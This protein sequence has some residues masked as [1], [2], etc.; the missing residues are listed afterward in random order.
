MTQ[1]SSVAK[2][3]LTLCDPMNRSTP[4]LP[5]HHQL[6]ESTQTHVHWVND[7]IQPSHPLLFPSPP[8]SVFPSIRVFSSESLPSSGFILAKC[9]DRILGDLS[10]DL[11]N[12]GA[13]V[14]TSLCL[15][16]LK[17]GGIKKMASPSK[18]RR[19]QAVV[20]PITQVY[21]FK[22]QSHIF[23]FKVPSQQYLY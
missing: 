9:T 13:K 23:F 14:N 11:P 7:A 4:G 20:G 21:W 2:S 1:F 16:F 12:L 18:V 22:C 17:V 5:V 15:I 3:C 8:A 10:Q 19:G 6:P